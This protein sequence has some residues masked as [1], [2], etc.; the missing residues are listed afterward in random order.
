MTRQRVYGSDPLWGA[1]VRS[2]GGKDGPLPSSSLLRGTTVND[3]DMI[4]HQYKTPVDRQG[5]RDVQCLMF[6]ECKT[7]FASVAATQQET[8][9]MLHQRLKWKGQLHTLNRARLIT[10]WLFGVSF[11]SCETDN[12]ATSEVFRWSRFDLNGNLVSYDVDLE[13]V[14]ALL[15]FDLDPDTLTL[16]SFRRHHKVQRVHRRVLTP[17]GIWVDESYKVAS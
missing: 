3:W 8:L 14:L 17:L 12:P 9:W 5:T 2:F 4:I 7:R 10:A 11:L 13:T 1:W 15:A 6:V 16:L